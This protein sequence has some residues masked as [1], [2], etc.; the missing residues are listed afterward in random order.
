ML[1]GPT[2]MGSSVVLVPRGSL[3]SMPTEI[4]CH[5]LSELDLDSLLSFIR[6]NKR[7]HKLF[8]SNWT[9]ILPNILGTEFSPAEGL[10]RIFD[11]SLGPL[12]LSPLKLSC[13]PGLLSRLI[14][15]CHTVKEW[16]AI[17]PALR[18]SHQPGG[19]SRSL[20]LDENGRLRRAIYTWWRFGNYFHANGP[21]T[22]E[23]RFSFL[24]RLSTAELYE[25]DDLWRTI[26]AAVEERICPS[27]DR[28]RLVLVSKTRD[29]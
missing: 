15:L 6:T 17:F 21:S 9:Y 16:E 26:Q 23:E 27:V 3:P 29:C 18:F 13:R 10:F 25:L 2:I 28:V 1:T 4:V 24:R 8:I 5:I 7:F 22:P 19:V 11:D 14:Q 20:G 12:I